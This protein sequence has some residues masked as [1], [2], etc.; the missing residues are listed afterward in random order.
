[1]RS[2][3]G[4]ITRPSSGLPKAFSSSDS[5]Q[6]EGDFYVNH[7]SYRLV[8]FLARLEAPGFHGFDRLFIQAQSQG[9]G[10]FDIPGSAIR[11]DHNPQ[12]A[13]TLKLCLP[14]FL[15]IFGIGGIGQS[16]A[17]YTAAHSIGSATGA[18]SVTG[19]KSRAFARA[20]ATT[21][22]GADAAA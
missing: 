6:A 5:V 22:S 4:R 18:A 21:V 1:M 3:N 11:A 12:H 16:G 14:G 2:K 19:A 13:S 15:R 7:R 10:Y 8:I 20:H 9:A 17:G